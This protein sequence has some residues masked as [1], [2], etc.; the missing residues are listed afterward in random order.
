MVYKG[1]GLASI[2]SFKVFVYGVLPGDV[3]LSEIIKRKRHYA[4]AKIVQ[5][6]QSSPLRCQHVC[7]HSDQCGGC[8]LIEVAY[9]QQLQIK[10]DILADSIKQNFPEILDLPAPIIPAEQQFYY[11]NKMEFA[12]GL[13]NKN[14]ILGLKERGSFQNIIKISECRLLSKAS[15][16]LLEYVADYFQKQKESVWNYT[17]HQGFLRY[18]VV[19]HSKTCDKY[20]INIVVSENKKQILQRFAEDLQ[21]RF[22][23]VAAIFAT[24]QSAIS[25]TT[26][27]QQIYLLQGEPH[28]YEKFNDIEYVISPQAFFQTNTGQAKLLYRKTSEIAQLAATDTV[29]DLYCGTGTIGIFLAKDAKKIIGI[30][31]NPAAIQDGLENIKS[32]QIENVEL[33]C[34]KVKNV[35]KTSNYEPNCIIID[36]PRAGMTPKA[37]QRMIQ[38]KPK[39]IIYIS[40]N[41][42]TLLRDLKEICQ[43]EYELQIFQPI[44]MF[45]NTYHIEI[46]TKLQR[47]N[48]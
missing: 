30:E 12:F 44:D 17:L 1:Y 45:P 18:L 25:D 31:E 46:I 7:P 10:Q 37:L 41:P 42:V 4:E 19:R 28:I 48:N 21:L 5:I 22:P 34:G 9:E 38:L 14:I 11:R 6:L 43:A 29:L 23:K 35:L 20:L 2:N 40:C 47:R 24:I 15:N 36:P 33:I 27:G 39:T 32:N 16:Q 8:Q 3:I 26:Q 13:E